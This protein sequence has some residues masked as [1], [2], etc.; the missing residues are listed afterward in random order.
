MKL[1][2]LGKCR[3]EIID[4]IENERVIRINVDTF[5]LRGYRTMFHGK[6][7]LDWFMVSFG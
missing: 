4:I 3:G 5:R 1:M 2:K 6:M 7:Y